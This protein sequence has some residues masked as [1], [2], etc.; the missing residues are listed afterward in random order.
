MAISLPYRRSHFAHICQWIPVLGAFIWF[1]T[2][3]TLLI[4]WLVQ[5]RPI[6]ASVEHRIAYISD[7]GADVLK[8]LFVASCT[9]TAASFFLSLLIEKSL[10][11]WGRTHKSERVFGALAVLYSFSGGCGLILLSVFDTK[12]YK[13]THKQCMWAFLVGV[14][15]S[16]FFTLIE[17]RCIGDGRILNKL[18]RAKAIITGILVVLAAPFAV[19]FFKDPD[20]GAI[21]EWGIGIGFTFLLLTS[22]FDLRHASGVYED[23]FEGQSSEENPALPA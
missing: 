4:T 6:Y 3:V 2:L 16:A 7:V 18:F 10:R 8:P 12:R 11:Y 9:I 5:G 19:E 15:M 23:E 21:L 22:F 17:Y 1:A 13:R 14:A 20:T